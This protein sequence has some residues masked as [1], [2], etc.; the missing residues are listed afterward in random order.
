[1]EVP[2]T[3]T[4]ILADPARD[5]YYVLRQDN[6]TVLVYDGANNS[7]LR[8]LRTNNV[9]TTLAVSFDQK[10][11]HIGHDASQK[12]P[13]CLCWQQVGGLSNDAKLIVGY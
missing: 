3:L 10:F 5:R 8:T 12:R 11:L 4:D 1:L 13:S 2:G 7:L 6:N 9:P